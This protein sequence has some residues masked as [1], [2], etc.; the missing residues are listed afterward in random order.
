MAKRPISRN[1]E[2]RRYTEGLKADSYVKIPAGLESGLCLWVRR[3]AI[4][5][6]F[7]V[8]G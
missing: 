1:L 4:W 5:P 2:G 8:N 7:E 3:V 6:K